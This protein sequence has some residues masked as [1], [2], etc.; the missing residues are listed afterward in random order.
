MIF[1]KIVPRP[2]GMLKQVF[3][4]RFDP[5][6]ARFGPWKIPKCLESGPV[7]NQKWVKHGSK[8]HFSVI[9]PEPF[10][11]LEHVFLAHFEPIGTGLGP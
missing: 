8:T 7:S 10:G 4:A 1:S 5:V 11:M 6:V 2:L 9:D 3:L